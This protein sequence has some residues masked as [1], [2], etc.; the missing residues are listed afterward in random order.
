MAA[1]WRAGLAAYDPNVGGIDV[2]LDN[3]L[4]PVVASAAR[5]FAAVRV[6]LADDPSMVITAATPLTDR[7]LATACPDQGWI[8]GQEVT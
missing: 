5:A 3:D 8:V 7:F 6:P 4:E 2:A 1:A